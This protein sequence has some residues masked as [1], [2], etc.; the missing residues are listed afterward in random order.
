VRLATQ[1]AAAETAS[2]PPPLSKTAVYDEAFACL[3]ISRVA[4]GLAEE[5][6]AAYDQLQAT[7][8]LKGLVLD[9]RFAQ[10]QNYAAAA[11]VADRFLSGEQPLLDWGETLQHSTAKTNAIQI[12]VAILANRH[13]AGAAEALAAVLRHANVGL[14]IGNRTAGQAQVFQ[15]FPL[16]NG[17]RLRIATAAIKLG[18][19]QPMSSEGL[20]PDI[21]VEITEADERDYFEDAFRVLPKTMARFSG[22]GGPSTNNLAGGASTNR[23]SRRRINEAELVRMQREGTELDTNAPLAPPKFKGSE[24]PAVQDPV[25]VRALDLLKGISVVQ[26]RLRQP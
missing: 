2:E 16:A 22:A 24:K 18:N 10:G 21:K 23:S 13:T 6:A 26:R 15:E 4:P 25:L 20:A 3:R 7:H 5:I 1:A 9:L 17:Q 8:K 12:P 19:D 11:A 14:V